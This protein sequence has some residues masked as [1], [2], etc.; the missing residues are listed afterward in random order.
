[1]LDEWLVEQSGDWSSKY[2]QSVVHQDFDVF[3]APKY[4]GDPFCGRTVAPFS[5]RSSE[6]NDW[7]VGFRYI[8][9]SIETSW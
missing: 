3:P 4:C 6:P 7:D 5:L 2:I 1:M 8:P 9:R